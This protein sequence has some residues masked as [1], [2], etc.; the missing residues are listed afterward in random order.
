MNGRNSRVGRLGIGYQDSRPG[1]VRWR[2]GVM[3]ALVAVVGLLPVAP[4]AQ[5]SSAAPGPPKY[6]LIV[7]TT[8]G[9]PGAS[10]VGHAFV[11]LKDLRTNTHVI[12]GKYPST[13][14][15]F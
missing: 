4:L 9:A 8:I 1:G 11:D 6:Q 5:P 2:R 13:N 15:Y 7:Y 10:I 12:F 3:L 14:N